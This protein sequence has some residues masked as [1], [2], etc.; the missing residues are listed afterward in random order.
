MLRHDIT[1]FA[2]ALL[3]F[4]AA[5]STTGRSSVTPPAT[6]PPTPAPACPDRFAIAPVLI[7]DVSGTTLWGPQ[8]F[9]LVVYSDGHALVA[10]RGSTPDSG[11]SA[12]ALLEPF[13][14]DQL[15][16]DLE[17]AN[18]FALCDQPMNVH[19]VPL[20]TVSVFRGGTDAQSRTFSYFLPSGPIA[21]V[22]WVVDRVLTTE[23]PG[24]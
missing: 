22:Q 16:A 5:Q 20:R 17:A 21:N 2:S 6:S 18:A 11:E 7:Y 23:F 1:L 24:L 19:D 8:Y 15:R 3:V 4:A 12:T 14:V 10:R 9:H 13:E